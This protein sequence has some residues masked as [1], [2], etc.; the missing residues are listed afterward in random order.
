MATKLEKC[1]QHINNSFSAELGSQFK[2]KFGRELETSFNLFVMQLVSRPSDGEPFTVE[3]KAWVE[4]WGEGYGIALDIVR[5]LSL[6][7]Q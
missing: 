3:Q 5:A 2:A 7:K 4:A 1:A 6:P